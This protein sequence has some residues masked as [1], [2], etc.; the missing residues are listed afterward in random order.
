MVSDVSSSQGT[1]VVSSMVDGGDDGGGN[2]MERDAK[3]EFR[4]YVMMYVVLMLVQGAVSK[5][6]SAIFMLVSRRLKFTIRNSL[7]ERILAQV[8]L[9][10]WI[11]CVFT[12][13]ILFDFVSSL[14]FSVC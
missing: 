8:S 9:S 13:C 1:A 12:S 2:D 7:L 6:F 5:G 4:Y 10:F 11:V 3:A 14:F